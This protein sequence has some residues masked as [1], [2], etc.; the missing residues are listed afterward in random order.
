MH[1][2]ETDGFSAG[3]SMAY[4]KTKAGQNPNT[5]KNLVVVLGVFIIVLL[6]ITAYEAVSGSDHIRSTQNSSSY[7]AIYA[8]FSDLSQS[9]NSLNY[10][11]YGIKLNYSEFQEQYNGVEH[12]ISNPYVKQFYN[13][14]TFSVP[15]YSYNYVF[16][17]Q[18]NGFYNN[19]TIAGIYNI[20]LY[21]PYF[22]YL[23]IAINNVSSS[24]GNVGICIYPNT[25]SNYMSPI[26]ISTPTNGF[27]YRALQT[28]CFSPNANYGEKF[29]EAVP[30]GPVRISF[31]NLNPYPVNFNTSITYVGIRYSQRT[32]VTF[33]YSN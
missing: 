8:K 21:L 3:T 4:K 24:A 2:I 18:T 7:N 23:I 32:N 10:S 13:N 9:Y 19:Y 1:K 14:R 12:N 28:N 6:F 20:T 27:Q 25:T 33:N 15:G 31:E 11:Y 5:Y 29:M 22:G 30:Y 16:Y 26:A 17:N